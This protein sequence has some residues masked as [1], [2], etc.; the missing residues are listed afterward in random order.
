M[1]AVVSCCRQ[2]LITILSSGAVIVPA[3][4][5]QSLELGHCFRHDLVLRMTERGRC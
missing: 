3:T 1:L 5:D 2:E 4:L